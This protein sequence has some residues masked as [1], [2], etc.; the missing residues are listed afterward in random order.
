MSGSICFG[1]FHQFFCSYL[2]DNHDDLSSLSSLFQVRLIFDLVGWILLFP[3][4]LKYFF[5]LIFLTTL[6]LE[7][8]LTKFDQEISSHHGQTNL[9][10]N[11]CIQHF[12]C[13]FNYL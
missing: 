1:W 13:F 11:E 2:S 7:P 8:N 5:I 4:F 3:F 10:K 9:T 6:V 12:T